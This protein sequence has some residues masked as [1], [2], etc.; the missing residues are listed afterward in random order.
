MMKTNQIFCKSA[1]NMSE[2]DD[3]SVSLVVT[4][5]PYNIDVRYGN[6]H[7]NG[8]AVEKKGKAYFD[9]R[10]ETE[11]R[12]LLKK[13]FNECKRVLKPNGSIWVNIK[14]RYNDVDNSC[15]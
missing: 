10:E 7:K 6:V 11:Y 5:P 9:N 15:F 2:L 4:S 8:R 12:E 14:N 3:N 1:E 13:V